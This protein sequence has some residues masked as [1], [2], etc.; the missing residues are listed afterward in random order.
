MGML[1]SYDIQFMNNS[2]QEII[3]EWNTKISIFSRSLENQPNYNEY[4]NEFTGESIC[5][6][7]IVDAER[8]DIVN[9][10]TNNP[11]PDNV[12]Y[13]VCNEGTIL[14]AIPDTI[15]DIRYKPLI[16]DIVTIDDSGDVYYI[17]SMRDRIGETLITIKRFTGNSPT[18]NDKGADG[19]F[20]TDYDWSDPT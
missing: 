12:D 6:R 5:T 19:I 18:I 15:S 7:T 10:M 11:E 20:I 4:M 8:K 16:S 1:N 3:K 17:R 13:G 2:V 14:F 9:N